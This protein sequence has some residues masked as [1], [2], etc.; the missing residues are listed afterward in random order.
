MKKEKILFILSLVGIFLLILLMPFRINSIEGKVVQQKQADKIT[1][2]E[3]ENIDKEFILFE[4]LHEKF[5]NKTLLIYCKKNSEKI[6]NSEKE[7]MIVEKI[8]CL[9]CEKNDS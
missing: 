8:L 4:S 6:S 7:Q 5:I 9:D 3:I 1:L 2:L